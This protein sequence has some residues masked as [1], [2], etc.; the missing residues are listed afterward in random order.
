MLTT[1][2]QAGTRNDA[3][4]TTTDTK[5]PIRVFVPTTRRSDYFLPLEDTLRASDLDI[6][7]KTTNR[8]LSDL[9]AD[10]DAYRTET[11]AYLHRLRD[12]LRIP[13]DIGEAR[14]WGW[15]VPDDENSTELDPV[16]R[17]HLGWWWVYDHT[18]T[19]TC[20][21]RKTRY[22]ADERVIDMKGF[23][24]FIRRA[25]TTVKDSKFEGDYLRR[26]LES[27]AFLNREARRIK[28]EDQPELTLREI[29]ETLLAKARKDVLKA[30]PRARDRAG[31]SDLWQVRDAAKSGRDRTA[32]DQWY[33]P[34][35]ISQTGRPKGSKTRR[36][37]TTT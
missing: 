22:L 31:Q 20:D 32:L 14:A 37:H 35:K 34:N 18:R 28:A 4:A 19:E 10:D 13:R 3:P 21:Q 6:T 1:A 12:G 36:R 15:T 5:R 24:A 7:R 33:E 30:H 16:K 25:Y 2:D 8:Q 11:L 17:K 9:V 27:P 26:L 29:S 23:A